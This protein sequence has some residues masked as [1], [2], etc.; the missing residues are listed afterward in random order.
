MLYILC[1]VSTQDC[2]E[3]EGLGRKKRSVVDD[4]GDISADSA[5]FF[6][7]YSSLSDNFTDGR[8]E[9]FDAAV[10]VTVSGS[11][12]FQNFHGKWQYVFAVEVSKF[13]IDLNCPERKYRVY[14]PKVIG[15]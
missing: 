14:V 4:S 6:D 5:E 13:Q 8:L 15:S 3:F 10:F 1:Y 12:V 9:R 11:K 7:I 2:Q